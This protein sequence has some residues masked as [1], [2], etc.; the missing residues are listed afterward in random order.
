MTQRD[1]PS[2]FDAISEVSR[3]RRNKNRRAHEPLNFDDLEDRDD[4]LSSDDD[5]AGYLTQVA[6]S[7]AS[8]TRMQLVDSRLRQIITLSCTV[9]GLAP[10]ESTVWES[11]K[12]SSL[13]SPSPQ[14]STMASPAGTATRDDERAIA[15]IMVL[16]EVPEDLHHAISASGEVVW[17][18]DQAIVLAGAH[19]VFVPTEIAGSERNADDPTRTI[20]PNVVSG[21]RGIQPDYVLAGDHDTALDDD[22]RSSTPPRPIALLETLLQ[23]ATVDPST[24]L[25]AALA[26]V[27]IEL[28][29]SEN[30]SVRIQR[31]DKESHEQTD[32]YALSRFGEQSRQGPWVDLGGLLVHNGS[33]S[34]LR[35]EECEPWD[36]F[37]LETRAP[38]SLPIAGIVQLNHHPVPRSSIG[39]PQ[40]STE[41]VAL[42]SATGVAQR[43][44]ASNGIVGLGFGELIDHISSC[45]YGSIA[46]DPDAALRT[47]FLCPSDEFDAA[48]DALSASGFVVS[49]EPIALHA[50]TVRPS[51]SVTW[52]GSTGDSGPIVLDIYK[53]LS[54]GPFSELISFD[55]FER[56]SLPLQIDGE[57]TRT[58]HPHHR[59][60]LHALIAQQRMNANEPAQRLFAAMVMTAPQSEEQLHLVAERAERWGVMSLMLDAVRSCVDHV[61]GLPP[62]LLDRAGITRR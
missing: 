21:L 26:P 34:Y 37:L 18:T 17:S 39:I 48:L 25:V 15:T 38:E 24:H 58:L 35:A 52:T 8:A 9:M 2:P 1:V 31:Y 43:V 27:A 20:H 32:A 10:R 46:A 36:L 22:T 28:L 6:E 61:G 56:H 59:F 42:K 44:L 29:Q 54:I 30:H 19:S 3:F 53:S 5:W 40:E 55:S 12:A 50:E 47:S 33:I 62:W 23:L 51:A 60:I 41:S 13:V 16:G 57:W 7:E 45:G 11:L 14:A 4:N 49:Q